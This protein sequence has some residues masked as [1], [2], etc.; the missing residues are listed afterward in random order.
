MLDFM[1]KNKKTL[2]IMQNSRLPDV[3]LTDNS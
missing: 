3:S 1:V 2:A